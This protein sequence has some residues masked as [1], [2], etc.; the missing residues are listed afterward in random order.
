MSETKMDVEPETEAPE[1][2]TEEAKAPEPLQLDYSEQLKTNFA[3]VEQSVKILLSP[4][5]TS[6]ASSSSVSSAS[7]SSFLRRALMRSAVVRHNI[8]NTDLLSIV[9]GNLRLDGLREAS[10]DALGPLVAEE[11]CSATD[12]TESTP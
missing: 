1:T 11:K 3:M 5:A 7:S 8:S 4:S 9:E 2:T 12:T 10:I 6:S